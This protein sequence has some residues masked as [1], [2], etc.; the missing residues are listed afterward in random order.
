VSQ[1]TGEGKAR[2]VCSGAR[3]NLC[4]WE[5]TTAPKHERHGGRRVFLLGTL[6]I[7]RRGYERTSIREARQF[8]RK[9]KRTRTYI[10]IHSSAREKVGL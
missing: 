10:K 5:W 7:G 6:I 4:Y 9:E 1:M 8:E 2:G 3:R